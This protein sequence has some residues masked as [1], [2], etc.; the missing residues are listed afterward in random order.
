MFNCS[1][2]RTLPFLIPCK[3][4]ETCRHA[5]V[6]SFCI[7]KTVTMENEIFMRPFQ[8]HYRKNAS[9]C[10]KSLCTTN[11]TAFNHV[12]LAY[13]IKQEDGKIRGTQ[14]SKRE[15]KLMLLMNKDWQSEQSLNALYVYQT[16][17]ES[18]SEIRMGTKSDYWHEVIQKEVLQI[19]ELCCVRRQKEVRLHLSFVRLFSCSYQSTVCSKYYEL[20][21]PWA[22][23]FL[24]KL[25]FWHSATSSI[26]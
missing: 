9:E 4:V 24:K 12:S 6:S 14:F 3:W 19:V 10:K 8:N 21:K 13:D 23:A 15:R 7:L 25:L 11:N 22:F 17:S 18:T 20:E 5:T 16:S 26:N 2:V 1:S